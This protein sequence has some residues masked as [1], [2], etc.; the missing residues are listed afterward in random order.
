MPCKQRCRLTG[1]VFEC[2]LAH[3][4]SVAA[5]RILKRS[6]LETRMTQCTLFMAL[7]LCRVC[8]CV[9]HGMQWSHIG[10]LMP[11]LAAEPRSSAYLLLPS[12]Y[13]CRTFLVNP[14]SMVCDWRVSWAGP[15]PIYWSSCLALFVSYCFPIL[16]FHFIGWHWG[17]RVFGLIGCAKL[18]QFCTANLF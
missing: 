12:Q 7:Y 10:T 5:L 14:Y 1:D 15:M 17:A 6:G 18:S 16:L 13:L 9:L 4:R 3:R 2:D 11:L 8:R